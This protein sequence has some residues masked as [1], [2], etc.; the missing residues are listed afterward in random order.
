MIRRINNIGIFVVFAC[1]L[2]RANAQDV[3][4]FPYSPDE[5]DMRGSLASYPDSHIKELI[6]GITVDDIFVGPVLIGVDKRKIKPAWNEQ[7]KKPLLLRGVGPD[8]DSLLITSYDDEIKDT[9]RAVKGHPFPYVHFTP[10][11]STAPIK[12]TTLDELRKEYLPDV[13]EPVVY[14]ID[15]YI[16]TDPFYF[17]LDH[18]YVGRIEK[19]NSHDIEALKAFPPFTFIRIF[20][21]T[22][23]NWQWHLN[24]YES[25]E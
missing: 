22:K 23:H 20:T 4:G 16:I 19:L 18:D 2:L 3:I 8:N 12:W 17:K 1:M 14:T 6:G 24:S 11:R 13:Q 10:F 5:G 15:K 7:Y 9:V 21:K 25:K